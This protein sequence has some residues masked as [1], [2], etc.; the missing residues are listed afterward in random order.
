MGGAIGP[1]VLGLALVSSLVLGGLYLAAMRA[2]Y[3]RQRAWGLYPPHP[4][5]SMA[6]VGI[7]LS[8]GMI[9]WAIGLS[10]AH[11]PVSQL[12]GVLVGLAMVVVDVALIVGLLRAPRQSLS[13]TITLA[14]MRL[15]L[16]QLIRG[17]LGAVVAMV[18]PPMT[19][20][21]TQV[22][23]GL[24][25]NQLVEVLVGRE[26][27]AQEFT[28]AELVRD[29][30]LA[31]AGTLVVAFFAATAAIGLLAL[32]ISGTMALP[33]QLVAQKAEAAQ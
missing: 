7:L 5:Q 23:L 27:A 14:Q 3:R 32:V 2:A 26:F 8:P 31:Q 21:A 22:G 10:T 28:L 1:L 20:V 9:D 29:V 33:A 6:V 13:T 15:A 25:T 16:S 12:V 30:Y 11:S 18:V 4:V 17:G 24:I 19:I